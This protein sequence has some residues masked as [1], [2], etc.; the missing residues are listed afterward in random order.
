MPFLKVNF[1]DIIFD[2]K[3]QTYCVSSSFKC[4]SYGHSWACP[5]EAPFME[6][7]VAEFKVFYLIYYKL[8]LSEYVKDEQIKHPKKSEKSIKTMLY[9]SGI[10]HNKLE[11]EIY[12]FIENYTKP[13]EEKLILWDGYCRVCSSKIDKG[14]T[15]DSGDPCRYP[16][17]RKYSMEAVGINVTKTVS[18]LN[19][20]IQWP[21]TDFLF[22]FGLICFK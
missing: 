2:S 13:Y 7:K 18:K 14:C 8:D 19:L 17:K 21:P 5:P 3:V 6:K 1:E 9:S 10:L 20:G 4:P 11:S 12:N 15:Y 22:R 16:E